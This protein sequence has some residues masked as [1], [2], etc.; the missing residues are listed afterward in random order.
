MERLTSRD[1]FGEV[2]NNII[3]KKGRVGCKD[4]HEKLAEYE[5]LEEQ[6]RLI[7]LPCKIGDNYTGICQEMIHG[8]KGWEMVRW[9]DNGKIETIEIIAI[10]TTEKAG[11]KHSR[12]IDELG[13][14]WFIGENTKK[15]AERALKGI[16][17]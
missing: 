8:R 13:K 12:N 14:C 9:L 1:K 5:D 3:D 17:I 7:K 4:I 6:G 2:I 15:E 16:T 11:Y 10:M